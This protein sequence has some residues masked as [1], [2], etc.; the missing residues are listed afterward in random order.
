MTAGRSL[1]TGE[2]RKMGLIPGGVCASV[3]ALGRFPERAVPAWILNNRSA[4]KQRRPFQ[5]EPWQPRRQG[6]SSSR[7]EGN[8]H[9][10]CC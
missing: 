4:K 5:E 10:W 1:R 8:G 3:C 7:S 6:R 2:A 9:A